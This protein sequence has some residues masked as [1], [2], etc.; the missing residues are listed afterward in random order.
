MRHVLVTGGAGFIGS[1]FVHYLLGSE[2]D[3]QIVTMDALTYA[4]SLE[5][6]KDLPDPSRH[7]FIHGD[8]AN[9]ELVDCIFAEYEID[10]VVHFAAESHVDR[11]ILDPG[12][13]VQTNV[14]GTFTLLE[15]ARKAWLVDKTVPRDAVRFHHVST[16]EVFGTLSKADPPFREETAYQPRSPYAASKAASD[17][18]VRAYYTTY[19]LPISIS[20]CSN[21]YGPRQFPEKLI[22]LMILNATSG[23]TL[24]IYGDGMQI[25]DWLYVDDHCEALW[26]VATQG[27]VGETYCIGGD[28]QPANLEIVRT[29]CQILDELQPDSPFTPHEQLMTFVPDRPGH[30]RRYDIDIS[31]IK[32]E[33]GWQPRHDLQQGL[34]ATVRWYLEHPEWVQAITQ[35]SDYDGWMQKNYANRKDQT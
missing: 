22:P 34:L 16:D 23:K 13:F 10:T 7:V 17:H 4:G 5:N 6:L 27:R 24:P 20:N 26:K 2:P 18:F 15:A 1:N 25:R 28:N 14:I 35:Q 29:I 30:D 21:N 3:V 31:K 8:I 11:S 33:L 9:R 19:G 12:A 32:S